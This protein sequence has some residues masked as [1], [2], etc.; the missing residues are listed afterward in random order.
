MRSKSFF[1]D[2]VLDFVSFITSTVIFLFN[3]DIV[4]YISYTVGDILSVCLFCDKEKRKRKKGK[5][6][7]RTYRII[8]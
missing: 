8:F 1:K 4:R 3:R 6:K 2:V 7:E 5:K